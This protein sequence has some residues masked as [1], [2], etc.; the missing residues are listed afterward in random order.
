MNAKV[1]HT[2]PRSLI[3]HR[4]NEYVVLFAVSSTKTRKVLTDP[5]TNRNVR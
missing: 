4:I 2:H 1:G 5:G 3:V